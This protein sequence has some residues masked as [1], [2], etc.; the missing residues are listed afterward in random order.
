MK[1]DPGEQ[2]NLYGADVGH[3]ELAEKAQP[4][5]ARFDQFYKRNREKIDTGFVGNAVADSQI[6]EQLK[7]LGYM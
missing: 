2:N 6:V 1:I 3:R 7:S 5:L 4:Y